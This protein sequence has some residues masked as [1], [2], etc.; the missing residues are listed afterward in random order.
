M[1]HPHAIHA[2]AAAALEPPSES[3]LRTHGLPEVSVHDAMPS[4]RKR[5][6]RKQSSSAARSMYTSIWFGRHKRRKSQANTVGS[7]EG[8]LLCTGCGKGDE[9]SGGSGHGDFSAGAAAAATIACAHI[10]S[11]G[12]GRGGSHLFRKEGD[13]EVSDNYSDDLDDSDDS[14][15]SDDLDYLDS[16]DSYKSGDVGRFG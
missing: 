16:D 4:V 7:K 8:Q 10:G 15:D 6:R 9:G 14:E 1:S 5:P 13:S 2:C 11:G 3:T 12:A